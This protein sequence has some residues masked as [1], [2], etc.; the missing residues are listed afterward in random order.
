MVALVGLGNINY[1]HNNRVYIIGSAYVREVVLFF[2]TFSNNRNRR[3][4]KT[5]DEITMKKKKSYNPFK[6]AGSYAGSSIG[7]LWGYVDGCFGGSCDTL[8]FLKDLTEGFS[9]GFNN[10]FN[11]SV[12][13]VA[14]FL[15]GWG[16]HSL[17]RK[18]SK[19]KI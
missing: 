1:N 2:N 12:F 16:I 11:L 9:V 13:I 5:F 10:F 3:Y 8:M 6:M 14:G 17:I 15:I 7:F 4:N 19:G 18:L